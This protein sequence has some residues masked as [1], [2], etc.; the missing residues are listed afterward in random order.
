M[1]SLDLVWLS[2]R[3]GF[4]VSGKGAMVRTTDGG[5]TWTASSLPVDYVYTITTFAGSSWLCDSRGTILRTDDEG[6]S[7]QPLG[8]AMKSGCQSLSFVDR[9]H[10]WISGSLGDA[11]LWETSDGGA[12]WTEV[13]LP[14]SDLQNPHG[15][16]LTRM[17]GW[18]G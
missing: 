17:V 13:P 18:A 11:K 12:T 8:S 5:R 10:G 6:A 14:Q 7:W 4:M 2:P 9:D 15:I 1:S 16:R 3:V